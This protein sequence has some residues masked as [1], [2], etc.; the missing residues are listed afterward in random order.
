MQYYSFAIATRIT[1]FVPSLTPQMMW[2]VYWLGFFEN[3]HRVDKSYEIFND[4]FELPI[5]QAGEITVDYNHT[6]EAVRAVE[7][8]VKDNQFPV[9]CITE[10]RG[11]FK[12]CKV[13]S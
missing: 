9:N 1:Y 12:M 11:L 6:V 13:S 2:L 4:Y 10:V 3:T 5:H 8:L 7:R